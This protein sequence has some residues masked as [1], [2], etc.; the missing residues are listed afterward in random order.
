MDTDIQIVVKKINRLNKKI[1]QLTRGE[2]MS[3]IDRTIL[4][5][6]DLIETCKNMKGLD[7]DGSNRV[8]I[9]QVH[10]ERALEQLEH[11]SIIVHGGNH[12]TV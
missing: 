10:L 8:F 11:I 1:E 12:G 7:L 5:L 4:Q 9:G 6:R 2:G 3:D